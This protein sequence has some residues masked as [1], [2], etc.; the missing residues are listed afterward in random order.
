MKKILKTLLIALMMMLCVNALNADIGHVVIDNYSDY[1]SAQQYNQLEEDLEQIESNYNIAIYFVFDSSIE[2]TEAGIREYAQAFIDSHSA[3]KNNV[4]LIVNSNYYQLVA[5]G[6]EYQTVLSDSDAIWNCFYAK[7][8]KVSAGNPDAFYEGIVDYYQY[9]VKLINEK[10]YSSNAP[11]VKGRPL[12]NDFANLMSDKEEAN[13]TA[14]LQKIKEKYGFD[15]VVV[16]TDSYNGMS[17]RD[18]CDDFYDYNGYAKDGILFLLGM[19][20]RTWYVSTKG[21]ASEYFTDY[22]IDEI[23]EEME[24]DLNHER[25]YDA[26]VVYADNVDKY[27][28]NGMKGNI[29]DTNNNNKKKSFGGINV[30]ISAIIGAISSLFTSLGLKGQM[31]NVRKEQFARNY[32][33]G[34]SFYLTGASDMLVNRHVSRTRRPRRED[35]GP[36]GR[37]PS[38]GGGG[39]SHIHTSS[40]GSSHGGHG[41]HF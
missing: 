7:A 2:N 39:G 23:F 29:I 1:M 17:A 37:I 19:D 33:V 13:L 6:S 31:K 11:T 9:V 41:G 16:T 24:S 36:S 35:S 5:S 18:Y 15:A 22:G 21:K 8:S 3:S 26:F 4:A 12:V 40:S 10:T 30:M 38:G 28:A 25:Y 27:I 32:I 34:N 14:K 20:D